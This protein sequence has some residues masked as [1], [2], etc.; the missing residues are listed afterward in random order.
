MEKSVGR[1]LP[2]KILTLVVTLAGVVFGFRTHR[3]FQNSPQRDLRNLATAI[4][5]LSMWI[6]WPVNVL[7][8]LVS[9]VRLVVRKNQELDSALANF[10]HLSTLLGAFSIANWLGASLSSLTVN[11]QKE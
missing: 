8:G 1:S 6:V 10:E 11:N 3:A 9:Q 5:M 4:P 7:S 2:V